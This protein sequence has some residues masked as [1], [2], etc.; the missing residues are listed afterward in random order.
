MIVS[1]FDYVLTNVLSFFAGVFF[2]LGVC[3]CHK[4]TFLQRSKSNNSDSVSLT[5]RHA[6]VG[7][8]APPLVSATQLPTFHEITLK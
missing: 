4:D 3:A 2:G 1:V 5:S 7:S 8:V 6:G